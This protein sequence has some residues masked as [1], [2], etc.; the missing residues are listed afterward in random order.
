MA[1]VAG[2]VLLFVVLLARDDAFEFLTTNKM[3]QARRIPLMLAMLGAA[4]IAIIVPTAV[5]MRRRGWAGVALLDRVSRSVLPLALLPLLPAF[6]LGVWGDPLF[7]ALYL[8]AFVL[9]LEWTSRVSVAAWWPPATVGPWWQRQLQ[10]RPRLRRSAAWVARWGPLSIVI[11][12]ALTYAVWAS[13]WTIA[14]HH[15]FL[16]AGFDLGQYDNL[17]WNTLHGDWLHCYPLNLIE[18]WHGLRNHADLVIFALLPFYAIAPRAETL[19]V[20]QATILGA[21]AIAVFLFA[22]RRLP[23]VAAMLFGLS[24][25]LYAPLASANFYDFHMQPLA[26]VFILYAIYFVDARRYVAFW[27]FFVLALISREDIAIGLSLL[28]LFLWLSGARPKVGIAATIVAILYFVL[29]RGVVMNLFGPWWFANIYKDLYP[30]DQR[31]FGGVIHTLVTNPTYVAG[32]LMT[33]AKMRYALQILAPLAFLPLRRAYLWPALIPGALLTLLTTEYGPTLSI[34]F[35]YVGHWI[36]YLFP[37][38][39]L[40]AAAYGSNQKYAQR[41]AVA[42]VFAG[43]L[44]SAVS[45]GAL[46]P[47]GSIHGGFLDIPFEP[48]TELHEKR[49]ATLHEFANRVPIDEKV[50]VGDR[51]LPHVS[52][53]KYVYSLR[54]GTYDADYLLYATYNRTV[55]GLGGNNGEKERR[56]R[57]YELVE[58]RDGIVLLKRAAPKEAAPTKQVPS[59]EL[60]KEGTRERATT[61]RP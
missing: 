25:L 19:L 48:P 13:K 43:T 60:P 44:L 32:T 59:G 33:K 29:M 45:W 46:S 55:R 57:T 30:Q 36:P 27:L 42:A 38:A 41:A 17:F 49:R 1:G 58:R 4:L 9:L 56:K 14:S 3:E 31:S 12:G 50:A 23:R 6:W 22:E 35:Q 51:E 20:I 61:K 40:A 10:S 18:D 7:L 5:V 8:T 24:Y 52:N 28:G 15:R 26:G 39:V 34:A 16:T 54:E 2:M 47:K 53:R 11:A 21:G 37:A